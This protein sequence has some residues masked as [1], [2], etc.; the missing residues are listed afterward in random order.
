MTEPP[1]AEAATG[2]THRPVATD[3]P[4]AQLLHAPCEPLPLGP[5]HRPQP[6]ADPRVQGRHHPRCRAEA[7]IASPA[8]EVGL[9]SATR[10][11]RLT[12]RLRHVS[13][14]TRCLNRARA[15]GAIRRLGSRSQ[16][17]LKPRNFRLGGLAT[18]LFAWFT[19]SLS[20]CVMKPLILSTTRC[21]A[22][23]VIDALL[24]RLAPATREDAPSPA[25]KE[26]P[27]ARNKPKPLRSS[28][29]RDR[30]LG[31]PARG[32][33]SGRDPNPGAAHRP[34]DSAK[35]GGGE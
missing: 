26:S 10:A 3:A 6:A 24:R 35:P 8:P 23:A 30:R 29:R 20:R 11:S 18:A 25:T 2:D 15:L 7:E 28:P 4:F 19:W 1:R 31:K 32:T 5:H 17:K 34:G 13:S 16:V 22:R 21:P 9:N 14:R 12:P 33:P 27:L